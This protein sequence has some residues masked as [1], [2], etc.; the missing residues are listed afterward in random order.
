MHIYG[1]CHSQQ[2]VECTPIFSTEN[3]DALT[4]G[5]VEIAER[6]IF[7]AGLIDC[8]VNSSGSSVTLCFKNSMRLTERISTRFVL[9]HRGA[10]VTEKVKTTRQIPDILVAVSAVL[11]SWRSLVAIPSR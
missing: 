5:G 8:C 3:P 10:K 11:G 1:I 4:R 6:D 7:V 2:P 9:K